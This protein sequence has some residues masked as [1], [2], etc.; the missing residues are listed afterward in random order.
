[1]A[2]VYEQNS[3]R[4]GKISDLIIIIRRGDAAQQAGN[5]GRHTSDKL[6]NVSKIKRRFTFL[7]VRP[8]LAEL[9]HNDREERLNFAAFCSIQERVV[10]D[11]DIYFAF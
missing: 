3:I 8:S 9:V 6:D 11:E 2:C 7:P 1:M 4:V 5:G 10:Q